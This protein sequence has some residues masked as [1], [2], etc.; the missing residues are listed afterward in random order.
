MSRTQPFPSRETSKQKY[1]FIDTLE[2]ERD[3]Y[4]EV[5]EMLR[6]RVSSKS[7]EETLGKA[8]SCARLKIQEI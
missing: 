1:S 4:K 8:S 2:Q 5:E 7:K 3:E 6:T